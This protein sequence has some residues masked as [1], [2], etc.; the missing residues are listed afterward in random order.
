M[1]SFLK[2]TKTLRLYRSNFRQIFPKEMTNQTRNII[3]T[4]YL[5]DVSFLVKNTLFKNDNIKSIALA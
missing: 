2:S 4:I 3:E 1:D 5:E